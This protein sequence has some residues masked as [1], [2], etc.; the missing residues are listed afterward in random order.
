[1]SVST[2]AAA[3]SSL[4]WAKDQ[5]FADLT[6]ERYWKLVADL[7]KDPKSKLSTVKF[8]PYLAGERTRDRSAHRCLYRTHAWNDTRPHAQCD[9]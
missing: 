5:L 8:D 1:M 7:A 3:G 2:L 4:N 9:H 6:P